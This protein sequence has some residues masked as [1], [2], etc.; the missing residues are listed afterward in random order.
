MFGVLGLYN[1]V[2]SPKNSKIEILF[3]QTLRPECSGGPAENFHGVDIGPLSKI[4]AVKC[5]KLYGFK[6]ATE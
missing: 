3:C 4:L 2:L 1:F 5:L 6:V